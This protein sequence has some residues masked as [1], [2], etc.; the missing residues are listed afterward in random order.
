MIKRGLELLLKSGVFILILVSNVSFF[1]MLQIWV[2]E[3]LFLLIFLFYGD[4]QKKFVRGRYYRYNMMV[5]AFFITAGLMYFSE[6]IF[7][8]GGDRFSRFLVVVFLNYYMFLDMK[9]GLKD[10][11]SVS[12]T[13]IVISLSMLGVRMLFMHLPEPVLFFNLPPGILFSF[14]LVTATLRKIVRRES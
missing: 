6:E 3:T 5:F 8:Q 2:I 14:A 10:V 1:S 9:N 4:I 11:A 7:Q 13:F 12:L